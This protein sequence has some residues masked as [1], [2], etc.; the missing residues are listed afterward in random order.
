[1]YSVLCLCFLYVLNQY[2]CLTH[3]QQDL[4]GAEGSKLERCWRREEPSGHPVMV[5]AFVTYCDTS[6]SLFHMALY[7]VLKNYIMVCSCISSFEKL[8]YIVI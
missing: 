4:F 3:S 2:C 7:L 5:I 6:W 1:M 8:Y